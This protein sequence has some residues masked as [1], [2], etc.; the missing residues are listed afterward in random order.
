MRGYAATGSAGPCATAG[1]VSVRNSAPVTSA[2]H[3]S[4]PA[5][6]Q[7]AVVRLPAP[8]EL[9]SA[10]P[11]DPPICWEV[12]TIAEATPASRGG[13]PCVAVANDG[14]IVSPK[15]TPIRI[16]DGSTCDA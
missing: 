6:H 9:S 12:L 14:A 15:P 16:S 3:T 11:I 2:P 13:I 1:R 4:S 10:A 7:Y 5:A 8:T